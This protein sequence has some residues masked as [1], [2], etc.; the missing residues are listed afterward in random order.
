MLQRAETAATLAGVDASRAFFA[1]LMV[2]SAGDTLWV[3]HVDGQARCI[4][5]ARYASRSGSDLPTRDILSDAATRGSAGVVLAYRERS[6]L[7]A[8][9]EQ[10]ER[11]S[12]R[13][14]AE[15]AQAVD[16]ALLDQLVFTGEQCTSMRRAGLL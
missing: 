6:T 16:V 12:L 14:L 10:A 13:R 11:T 8:L 5:L 2:G 3:A 1:P 4:H 9:P 15:A 7:D